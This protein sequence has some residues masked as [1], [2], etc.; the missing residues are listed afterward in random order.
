MQKKE[1]VVACVG[2]SPMGATHIP[3]ESSVMKVRLSKPTVE[4]HSG[5]KE[6]PAPLGRDVVL[7]LKKDPYWVW[8]LKVVVR[9]NPGVKKTFVSS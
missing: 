6:L 8:S 5:S 3:G 4:E 7:R 2:I 9:R 1:K